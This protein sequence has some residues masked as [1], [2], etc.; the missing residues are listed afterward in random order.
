MKTVQ[1]Y[2]I[3][4][5]KKS[6]LIRNPADMETCISAEPHTIDGKTVELSRATPRS[7]D[8]LRAFY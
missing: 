3:L 2:N 5:Y 6:F 7:V 1:C 8:N 4:Y